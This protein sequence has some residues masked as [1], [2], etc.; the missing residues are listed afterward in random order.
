MRW[1]AESDGMVVPCWAMSSR[2]PP[3]GNLSVGAIGMFY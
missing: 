2:R 3:W 1:V